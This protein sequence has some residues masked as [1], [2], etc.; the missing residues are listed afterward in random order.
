MHAHRER[1]SNRVSVIARASQ[2]LLDNAVPVQTDLNPVGK[3]CV[4]NILEMDFKRRSLLIVKL[5]HL[6]GKPR[7]FHVEARQVDMV[8]SV[9]SIDLNHFAG[10]RDKDLIPG[11]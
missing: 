11:F 9:A 5:D 7:P 6:I 1:N 10:F 8:E 4:S 3:Q 2:L